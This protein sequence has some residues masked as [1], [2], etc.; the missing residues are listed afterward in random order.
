MMGQLERE[1]SG[2]GGHLSQLQHR[3]LIYHPSHLHLSPHLTPPHP[4]LPPPLHDGGTSA[5]SAVV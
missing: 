4:A 5:A 2:V 1:W 3:T